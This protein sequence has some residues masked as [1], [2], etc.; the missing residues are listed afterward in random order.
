MTETTTSGTSDLPRMTVTGRVDLYRDVHKGLRHALFDLTFR[1][2]RLDATDDDLVVEL[3]GE[4]RRVVGLLR[5]HH[6]YEE[7][8]ALEQIVV[9]HAAAVADQIRQQHH[10]FAAWLDDLARRRDELAAT[11]IAAR[12]AIAHAYYLELA[13]FTSAYL[14]HLDDE[15]RVVLP[16]LAAACD[17]AELGVV[18]GA[19]LVGIRPDQQAVALSAMLP[20]LC[21]GERVS[22]LDRIRAT[23][24]PEAF[25]GARAIAAQV[26]TTHEYA[27]LGFGDT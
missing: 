6:E 3:V 1:A 12:A 11:A 25:M 9:T 4:S 21:P 5:D 14:A 19:I 27:H 26:L 2:G 23:A 22:L 17:D 16:A 13:A 8:A 18:L 7:Q 10:T 24:T 20:A 15:E